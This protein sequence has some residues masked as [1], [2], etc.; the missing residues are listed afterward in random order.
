L[1]VPRNRLFSASTAAMSR[2][3]ARDVKNAS[4]SSDEIN[5]A[6]WDYQCNST[7]TD[8][9]SDSG[10]AMTADLTKLLRSQPSKDSLLPKTGLTLICR[11]DMPATPTGDNTP[12][13]YGMLSGLGRKLAEYGS[14]SRAGLY[15][16]GLHARLIS[17]VLTDSE[18]F[19]RTCGDAALVESSEA[20]L[21]RGFQAALHRESIV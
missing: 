10:K 8:E 5:D 18:S 21:Q 13:A 16:G 20:I 12:P 3:G 4:S 2:N 17:Q 19:R 1:P 15:V 11:S 6:L 14:C 9:N 7:N